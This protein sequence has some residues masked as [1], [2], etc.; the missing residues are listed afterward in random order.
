MDTET[1]EHIKSDTIS[2]LKQHWV[3]ELAT[4]SD[5][6]PAVTPVVYVMDDDLHFYFITYRDT[7]KARNLLVNPECSLVVWEFL[8][9]SVQVSG[10][11]T[12]VEDEA[13][14]AWVVEA[15]AD[16]A[17]KDP[18]FWAPIF[19][20]QGGDYAVFEIQPTW[21]KSLDLTHST[22]RQE[23]SPFTEITL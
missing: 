12:L 7:L 3:M 15:F 21:M 11:A 5:Q 1:Y 17:T 20:I 22:V 16:A 6:K 23:E 13:K 2:F 10:V 18:N 19:R 4:C 9:M 14:K 8:H